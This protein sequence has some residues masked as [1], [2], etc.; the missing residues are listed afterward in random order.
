MSD[1]QLQEIADRLAVQDVVRRYFEL[2]DTKA[3]DRF[4]EVVTEDTT[5]R[6]TPDGMLEGRESVVGATRHMIGERRDRDVSPRRRHVAGH[7]RRHGGGDRPGPGHAP[8]ARPAG[9]EVLRESRRPAHQPGA[10]RR[11]LAHH[12][13]TTGTSWSS[14]GAWR[15]CSPRRSLPARATRPWHPPAR[16]AARGRTRASR[17]TASARCDQSIEEDLA[18]WA[19]L[20]ID[21]VGLI[22]PKLEAAGWEAS[23]KAV[24]DADLLVSSMSA[25]RTDIVESLPF[26][27]AV[28]CDVLYTVSGSF[29]TVPWEECGQEVLRGDGPDRGAGQGV[30]G[31]AGGRADQSTAQRRELRPLREGRRRPGPDGRHR[32]RR[33]LLLGLVRA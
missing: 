21:H 16:A 2:V 32:H 25:Y 6:W 7:R 28:G 13:T 4:D 14:S 22:S 19:E 17:S 30:R 11:G 1:E 24:L 33:R 20:G 3:W 8:R 23:Q 27:A 9:R 5:A 18:L 15:S 12:A 29:G 10:H 31:A 26:T